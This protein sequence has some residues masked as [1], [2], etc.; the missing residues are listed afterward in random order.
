MTAEGTIVSGI[1]GRY[2]TALFELADERHTLDETA[3]D[4]RS[5]ADLI[6]DSA[7][8]RRL[9]RSPM[10]KSDDQARAM[11]AVLQQA[12]AGDLI[13]R[14]V[15]V[16]AQNRRLFALPDV[17]TAFFKLLARHRGEVAADV[18]SATELTDAQMIGIREALS[19]AVGT[20]VI[21][22]A[23]VDAGL[24]GGLVVRLGSRMVDSS[25][26][27]KLENLR[28]AMKGIG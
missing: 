15:G 13:Q 6:D 26:R 7:D 16:V 3:E 10:I 28:F 1:A 27:T 4:L 14:F 19:Q 8:L 18:T 24:I 20:D 21:L 22:T 9:V 12:G 5:L 2:A 25:I 17:I 23:K 11:A